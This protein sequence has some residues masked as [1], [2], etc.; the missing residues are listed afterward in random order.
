MIKNLNTIKLNNNLKFYLLTFFAALLFR[1]SLYYLNIF[2]TNPIT[3][4]SSEYLKIAES[5]KEFH[6]FGIDGVKDMNRTPVYPLIIFLSKLLFFSET[7]NIILF[8]VC[9]D[10]INC[11]LIL[12]I[13]DQYR[14]KTF[15]KFFLMIMLI[16]CLY[17]SNYSLKIMTETVY[18]FFITLSLYIISNKNIISKYLFD[19]KVK[20]LLIFSLVLVLIVLT[21]PIFILTIIFFL[22]FSLIYIFFYETKNLKDNINK[23]LIFGIFMSLIISPWSIRNI[24]NF[25]DDI[26]AKNSI[27]TPIG[28]KTNYN[29]WKPFYLDEYKNFLKSYEEPFF[30]YSPIEPP[31]F[32]KYVYENEKEDVKKAFQK[33]NETPN[34]KK[35]KSGRQLKYSQETKDSFNLITKKRYDEKPILYF[36]API[37]R[38]VKILFSPRISSFYE[39]KSGFNSSKLSLVLFSAYN[40]LYV[41]LGLFFFFSFKNFQT[42]K[43]L[44]IFIFSLIFSHVY[45]HTIWVPAPQSRYLIPLFPIFALLTCISVDSIYKNLVKKINVF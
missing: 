11:C 39:K 6:I 33:L 1:Y 44:F 42:N 5:I 14:L 18:S 12:Y 30:M 9:L 37:S 43:V 8:Q 29:M 22:I 17:T 34:I 36:T 4:D 15:S 40:F 25:G 19:I 38:I 3:A 13:A 28:Y 26:F 2:D 10:S 41:F 35:G 24:S 7:Q 16:T 45:A 20:H 32:A 21:R 27:A 23:I 31:I